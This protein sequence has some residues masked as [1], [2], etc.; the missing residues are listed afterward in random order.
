MASHNFTVL[1]EPYLIHNKIVQTSLPPDIFHEMQNLKIFQNFYITPCNGPQY[2]AY[3]AFSLLKI[4]R[5]KYFLQYLIYLL[6]L[7]SDFKK[8]FRYELRIPFKKKKKLKWVGN[9]GQMYKVLI[10]LVPLR[11][12]KFYW[13]CFF[14]K[15]SRFRLF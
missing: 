14:L 11:F 12:R 15:W 8:I 9:S 6:K 2:F 10:R 3:V 5:T 1:E 13:K 7:I 4:N